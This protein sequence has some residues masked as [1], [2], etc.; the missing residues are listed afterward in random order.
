M[1]DREKLLVMTICQ[2]L[3]KSVEPSEV[4]REYQEA[5][6][7]LDSSREPTPPG[8]ISRAPRR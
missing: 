1:N 5:K 7:K 2:L 6:R 3:D 4:E 8:Y